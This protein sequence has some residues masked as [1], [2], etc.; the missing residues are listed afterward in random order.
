M[1]ELE[2]REIQV[3]A[4]QDR[5]EP[6][7]FHHHPAAK[8]VEAYMPVLQ[9]QW[10]WLLQLTLCFET[11]LRHA[12]CVRNLF[13]TIFLVVIDTELSLFAF[14]VFQNIKKLYPTE[15]L[16][17]PLARKK[18]PFRRI[19]VSEGTRHTHS[20]SRRAAAPRFGR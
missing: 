6:L 14:I 3:S 11:H 18:K 19:F 9:T 17:F 4:M 13:F 10:H 8:C 20:L 5:G 2:K 16:H 1:S 12:A 7:I 15:I